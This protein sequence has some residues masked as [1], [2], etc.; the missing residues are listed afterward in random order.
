MIGAFEGWYFAAGQSARRPASVTV[1]AKGHVQVRLQAPE[2]S[3]S[4]D[5]KDFRIS[6]RIGRTPRR[7]TLQDGA[8]I[9]TNDNDAVDGIERQL[10]G[11]TRGA[12]AHNLERLTLY[13]GIFVIAFGVTVYAFFT[14][15]VP[16]AAKQVAYTLPPGIL[17]T[18]GEQTL[19]LMD[20][21][22]FSPSDLKSARR[23][24]LRTH[25]DELVQTAGLPADCCRLLF[26][27]SEALG[28]NAFAL[29]DGSVILL[30]DIID[31]ATDERQLI[32]VMAHELGHVEERHVM[33]SLLQGAVI[34]LAV[35]F[36]A[37]D[38]SGLAELVLTIPAM[39]V[40][41]GYSRDFEREA[42]DYGA[43]LMTKLG[44]DPKHLADLFVLLAKS[45]GDACGS[46]PGW[47]STHPSS[48]ER[49]K[50]LTGPED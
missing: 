42:D 9:E 41:T 2:E 35:V 27:K 34:T 50:R 33:R 20:E 46:D 5:W 40:Q 1:D 47:L 10:K 45:C 37:G 36:V 4:L 24:E 49:V 43:A 19:E 13:T 11:I 44:H 14:W 31:L 28:A 8:V 38:L 21:Y 3:L 6:S 22:Y 16:Y 18:T 29:P 26:R 12:I 48:E 7:L 17:D 15:G 25:F 23:A 30:D 39:L 32:G